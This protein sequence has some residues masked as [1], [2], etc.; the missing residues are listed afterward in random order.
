MRS[1]PL[2]TLLA[3][4]T[5][6]VC[7]AAVAGTSTSV[8]AFEARIATAR[9]ATSPGGTTV[10]RAEMI[11]ALQVFRGDDGAVDTAEHQYLG[12]RLGSSAFL[13]GVTGTAKKY[14]QDFYELE[15]GASVPAP[16]GSTAVATPAAQLYGAS[17]P[18]AST[19][20]I[21]EG[22]IPNGQGV[23]NQVTLTNTY[24]T[25]FGDAWDD[26]LWFEPI[27][28]RELTLQLEQNVEGGLPTS[29]E[30]DGA[31]AYITDISRNSSRLYVAHW[32]SWGA[33][34]G[35]GESAGFI[36]AA[37]STD[38]RFVRMVNFTRWAE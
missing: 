37:V 26:Q 2:R 16:L 30:V 27:T 17:G 8:P 35:P 24:Y 4:V 7:P 33:P 34:G 15:D 14:L 32:H 28:L 9:T 20:V 29:D 5:L 19:S 10:I 36:V 11:S 3:S 38:R 6:L 13:T 23:A 18:L 12:T 1:L 22:F 21:R 31:L 25:Y